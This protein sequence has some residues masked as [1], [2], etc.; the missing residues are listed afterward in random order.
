MINNRR[1]FLKNAS[2]LLTPALLPVNAEA[3]NNKNEL[4]HYPSEQKWVKFF[5]EGEW[6]DEQ[7]F[8]DELQLAAKKGYLKADRYGSGGAVEELEKRMAAITGKEKAIF[9]PSGTMA[10]QLAIATLSGGNT[11]IFLQD[12]SHVYR[13]EADAAES[14]HHKRLMPLAFDKTYFT[15]NELKT[16]IDELP[17]KEVFSSGVGCVSIENPVRRMDERYVPVEEIKKINTYCKAANIKMHMDGARIFMAAAWSGTSVK[18]YASYFDTVYISLYKY[19][20]AN[21]GAILCG[22]KDLIDKMPHLIKVHG[23]SMYNN[24]SNAAMALH[25]LDGFEE[26]LQEA[27]KR[28]KEIFTGLNKINGVSVSALEGGSNLHQLKIPANTNVQVLREELAKA[29]IRIPRPNEKGE[30]L[31]SVNETLLFAEPAF[32][33]NAMKN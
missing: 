9:M 13:D 14:V 19:L 7:G 18:E 20:G 30:V 10:N 26:R 29:F 28:S 4:S 25:R 12:T 33:I 1:T 21:A 32:I 23:G 22:D 2:L 31:I 16:A 27:I 6:F 15:A 8:L 17:D 11:K 24:F 5:F 3:K